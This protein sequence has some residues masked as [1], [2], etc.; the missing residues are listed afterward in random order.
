[1]TG[2]PEDEIAQILS[3][4]DPI[5]TRWASGKIAQIAFHEGPAVG[6]NERAAQSATEGD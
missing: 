6:R 1:M 5:A 4:I 2:R 3:K